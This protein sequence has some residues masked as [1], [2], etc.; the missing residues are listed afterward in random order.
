MKERFFLRDEDF[1]A[2]LKP[3]NGGKVRIDFLF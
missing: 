3:R 2:T 1:L